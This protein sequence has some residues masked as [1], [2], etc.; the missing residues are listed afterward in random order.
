MTKKGEVGMRKKTLAL[1]ISVAFLGCMLGILPAYSQEDILFLSDEAFGKGQRPPAVFAHDDHNEK[2]ELDD[3]ATCHHVHRDG[4]LV[5]DE[6]SE[7]M[8]CSDCHHP[9]YDEPTPSL[10]KAY[11]KMCQGCHEEEK[12]GPITCGE[13]HVRGGHVA[14]EESSSDH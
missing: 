10:M 6:S 14:H 3:C 12:A 11:H 4:M 2:A 5:E 1:I 9:K 8:S 13:C 7:D